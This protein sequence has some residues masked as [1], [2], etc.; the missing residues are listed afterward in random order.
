MGK[1]LTEVEGELGIDLGPE[2][3]H[4]ARGLSQVLGSP[5]LLVLKFHRLSHLCCFLL[6]L[7]STSIEKERKRRKKKKKRPGISMYNGQ[8]SHDISFLEKKKSGMG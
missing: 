7:I 1:G 2:V 8:I 3:F 6:T 4:V 5:H